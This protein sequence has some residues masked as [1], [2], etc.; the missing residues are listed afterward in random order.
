MAR[1]VKS[2]P[3]ETFQKRSLAIRVLISTD[4]GDITASKLWLLVKKKAS[5]LDLAAVIT[6]KSLNN[7]GSDS[8]AIVVDGPNR[9]IDFF[10]VEADTE[11]L[12]PAKYNY[13]AVIQFPSGD[14]TQ[15][16]PP[17]QFLVKQP[18]TL[19]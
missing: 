19:T 18:V 9:I 3:V 13:D 7:G 4:V 5:D 12:E 14:K 11:S 8:E 2:W 6:K 1:A 16:V 10:I 15:L 17:S